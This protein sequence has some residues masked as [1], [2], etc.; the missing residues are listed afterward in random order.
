MN[1]FPPM[2]ENSCQIPFFK[3]T[4]NQWKEIYQTNQETPTKFSL[5]VYNVLF[6]QEKKSLSKESLNNINEAKEYPKELLQ[7]FSEILKNKNYLLNLK[8]IQ[9]SSIKVSILFYLLSKEKEIEKFDEIIK[10]VDKKYL[11]GGYQHV[12]WHA[13]SSNLYFE[14]QQRLKNLSELLN[15]CVVKNYMNLNDA[16][17]QFASGDISHY[18]QAFWIDHKER[19]LKQVELLKELQSDCYIL[20]EIVPSH[21]NVLMEQ[22][23]VRKDYYLSDIFHK[24]F[25][26]SKKSYITLMMTKLPFKNAKILRSEHWGNEFIQLKLWNDF[27]IFGAHTTAY[28][29]Y[30][31][32]RKFQLKQMMSNEVDFV[33]GGDLNIHNEIDEENIIELGLIDVWNFLY[34]DEECITFDSDENSLIQLIYLF[35][36]KRKMQ[37]DRVLMPKKSKIVPQMMKVIAKEHIEFGNLKCCLSDHFGLQTQINFK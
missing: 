12:L 33:I 26:N 34:P 10:T 18:T 22:D 30:S 17:K 19:F 1:K 15:H 27:N 35:C 24:N 20:C 29:K 25:S 32:I 7:T 6:E 9:D 2:T 31:E 5:T 37:L 4:E 13:L 11:L 28:D 3:F 8:K 21:V 23:W 36:E 16:V 14:N